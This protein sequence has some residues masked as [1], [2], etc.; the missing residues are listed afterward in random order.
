MVFH[1]I[2]Y[3][4][5]FN[6]H[7]KIFVLIYRKVFFLYTLCEMNGKVRIDFEVNDFFFFFSLNLFGFGIK[8]F[9]TILRR[10]KKF[11]FSFQVKWF[12][13]SQMIVW[14]RIIWG[15]FY[16]S[17]WLEEISNQLWIYY[18]GRSKIARNFRE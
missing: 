8:A 5:S 16:Y 9:S 11:F 13:L 1:E 4:K 6:K 3:E 7:C 15:L 2:F 17:E 14:N 18:E 10:G 12:V